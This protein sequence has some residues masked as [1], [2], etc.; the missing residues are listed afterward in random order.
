MERE[1]QSARST[2]RRQSDEA[3]LQALRARVAE[4]EQVIVGLGKLLV[5]A[6]Q[7]RAAAE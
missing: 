2:L 6:Q 3:E 7:N 4:L 5:E 1:E